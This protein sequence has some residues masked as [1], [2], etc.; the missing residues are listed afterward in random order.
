MISDAELAALT[1]AERAALSARLRALDQADS[2]DAHRG[3]RLRFL[4]VLSGACVVLIPWTAILAVT[5]PSAH[6]AARWDF[7]WVGFDV[8]LI[9]C[10][11]RTA[12]LA[13]GQRLAVASWAVVT[14]TLLV[15]DA[16]FDVTTASGRELIG[17]VASALV[18][19][20]P[21]TGLLFYVARRVLRDR[22]S[23]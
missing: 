20:L 16:W 17:S 21:L 2:A 14:G 3:A 6:T 19:E 1:V 7:T 15:S 12:W 8:A 23:R 13:Y 22:L 4:V 11:A 10:L 9:C 5:L 18:A